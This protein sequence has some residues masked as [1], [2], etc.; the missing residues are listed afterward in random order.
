M[1]RIAGAA[2]IIIG[3]TV[4]GFKK[5]YAL[6]A[7]RDLIAR[8]ITAVTVLE[9][10]I[11]YARSDL[12]SIFASVGN[13]YNLPIFEETAKNT[14]TLGFC[15]AMRS[16]LNTHGENL[17]AEDKSALLLLAD[18]LGISDCGSQLYVTA[19]VRKLLEASHRTA[20]AEYDTNGRMY[21]NSCMLFG[22]LTA[23]LLY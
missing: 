23:I 19:H 21:R 10:E 2:A 12:K 7:R 17:T 8:L 5:E 15:G 16:A 4:F 1:F 13:S 9:N 14:D 3:S 11:S 22:V 18:N 20:C 6:K